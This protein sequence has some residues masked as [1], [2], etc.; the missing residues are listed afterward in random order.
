[1]KE[2]GVTIGDSDDNKTYEKVTTT[3]GNDRTDKLTRFLRDIGCM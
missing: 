2:L 1:M 3:N